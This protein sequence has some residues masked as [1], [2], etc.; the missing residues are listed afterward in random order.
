M[1][2]W[3]GMPDVNLNDYTVFLDGKEVKYCFEACEESGR[4]WVEKTDS[5]G[6][7]VRDHN[8]QLIEEVLRGK[9]EIRKI[10]APRSNQQKEV[11]GGGSGIGFYG[12]G[13]FTCE[14]PDCAMCNDFD[15]TTSFTI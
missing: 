4:V 8:D 12:G 11:I 14:D 9:V 10:T 15:G 3:V 5:E 1:R 6:K 7:L 13:M 2:I